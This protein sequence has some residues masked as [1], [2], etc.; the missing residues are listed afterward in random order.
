MDQTEEYPSDQ[1]L[2]SDPSSMLQ[3]SMVSLRKVEASYE[4]SKEDGSEEDAESGGAIPSLQALCQRA[5][6]R[7]I[8]IKTAVAALSFAEQFCAGL[9]V[10]YCTQYIQL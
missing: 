2:A 6:A 4:E 5:V 9:L 1:A 8:N 3:E 10:D 7:T